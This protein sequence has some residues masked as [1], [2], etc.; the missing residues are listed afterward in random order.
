LLPP[1]TQDAAS[2]FP[3]PEAFRRL[4]DHPGFARL[5]AFRVAGPAAYLGVAS[6][7]LQL[8]EHLD[9]SGRQGSVE[10]LTVLAAWPGLARLRR[11]VLGGTA[12][13]ADYGDPGPFADALGAL[14]RSPYWGQLHE[15]DLGGDAE[16][17]PAMAAALGSPNLRTLRVLRVSG[18]FY[19]ETPQANQDA[20]ARE[21]AR[22]PH[23]ADGLELHFWR[24]D[25]GI[26]GGY[27]TDAGERLLRER[28]GD[29]LYLTG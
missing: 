28:F 10:G 2:E 1:H 23:L 17:L 27:L 12:T 29:G 20:G 26:P 13:D 19:D 3:E 5:R 22:C 24:G 21:L 18:C 4:L 9:L 6:A 15:L 16:I 8:L 11:L 14:A 7:D 25:P